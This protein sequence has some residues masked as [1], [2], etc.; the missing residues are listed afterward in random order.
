MYI[1]R[2]C[3]C[4][5]DDDSDFALCLFVCMFFFSTGLQTDLSLGAPNT[6]DYLMASGS[7]S[8]TI[9]EMDDRKE[10]AVTRYVVI[11][12]ISSLSHETNIL[13]NNMYSSA[14]F[15]IFL[16]LIKKKYI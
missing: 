12:Y 1:Y 5:H 3:A 13:K 7:Q 16:F 11:L 6:Y 14:F 15:F 9:D 4:T 2:V 10:L 8:L